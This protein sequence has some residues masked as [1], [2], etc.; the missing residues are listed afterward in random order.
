MVNGLG[1][2]QVHP[3]ELR[4]LL[5]ILLF[6]A[7]SATNATPS[8]TQGAANWLRSQRYSISIWFIE[9]VCPANSP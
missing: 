8:G 4:T 2:P 7:A 9:C 6:A 1:S 5:F 3:G